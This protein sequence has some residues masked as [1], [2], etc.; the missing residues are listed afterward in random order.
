MNADR[1]VGA[2]L[3]MAKLRAD[4]IKS[5]VC[6][7][8]G[9]PMLQT[10]RRCARCAAARLASDR[11]RRSAL[12]AAGALAYTTQERDAAGLCPRCG[13]QRDSQY[14]TCLACRQERKLYRDTTGRLIMA[15]R[16]RS[17]TCA[18]CASPVVPGSHY[19]GAHLEGLRDSTQRSQ[20]KL[21]ARRA[22]RGQC[23]R[24]SAPTLPGLDFCRHHHVYRLL[25]NYVSRP[26]AVLVQTVISKFD[27]RCAYSG[28]P[29]AMGRD[30]QLEHI[31]PKRHAPELV[32]EA[33]NLVWAHRAVNDAK[34]DLLP[35][36]ALLEAFLLPSIVTRIR[37]LAS[38][39]VR[40]G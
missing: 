34:A 25:A 20:Q 11:A 5:G 18:R 14:K 36:D 31:Y 4:R 33:S 13:G 35:D 26:S 37:E 6:I 39:V 10:R 38:K 17:G 19:C 40:P 23:S 28:L 8:C 12:Q 3:A 21:R 7:Q 27:G 2:K 1:G 32:G 30:G 24:C 16:A 15:E 29:I 22:T 9:D